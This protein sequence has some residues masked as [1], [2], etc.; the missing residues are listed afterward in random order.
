M[1]FSPEFQPNWITPPG[2]TISDILSERN[3]S[4]DEFAKRSNF[5]AQ[6]VKNLLEGHEKITE[7]IASILVEIFEGP[8]I[9]FWL[10]RERNYQ[11]RKQ[12]LQQ[13][14]P[15]EWLA[16]LPTKD[17]IE[18]G[19]I[20]KGGNILDNCLQFFDVPDI[21]TWKAKYDQISENVR[22]RTTSVFKSDISSTLAWLRRGEILASETSCEKWNA[23]LLENELD[24]I[25]LLSKKK[26]PKVF[27]PELTEICSS[28]GVAVSIAKT[29]KGCS[30]SGA[31]KFLSRQ[32][33][34]LLLS[35]RYLS[36]DQFWFTFFHE[37]GHLLMHSQ[38]QL[39]IEQIDKY[40]NQNV[41][42]EE[43][44]ANNFAG[45]ILVPSYFHEE[46][47]KLKRNKRSIVQFSMKLGVS[48]G[49]VIG[50]M[51][52]LGLIDF[53]YLNSYKRRYNWDEIDSLTA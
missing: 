15:A 53:K 13:V 7:E 24:R 37:I 20:A 11:E 38:K 17:M 10:E 45:E 39:F 34:M 27:L 12:I 21:R 46:L 2:Q 26:S 28:F 1:S 43:R 36:D 25:K 50:Q 16:S 30:A 5:S 35:F 48:P 23:K 49:I 52:H 42:H 40:G 22:F 31:T 32:K 33:A 18:L 47:R 29:P 51:Q 3:I 6:F 19:W 14:S 4:N 8:S 44:D 9:L 41:D